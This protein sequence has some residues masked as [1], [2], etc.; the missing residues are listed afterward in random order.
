MFDWLYSVIDNLRPAS[1]RCS[2]PQTDGTVR[3]GEN[4]RR[5]ALCYTYALVMPIRGGRSGTRLRLQIVMVETFIE[6]LSTHDGLP[7]HSSDDLSKP[8]GLESYTLRLP[9]SHEI[10]P[11]PRTRRPVQSSPSAACWSLANRAVESIEALT[12]WTRRVAAV[13]ASL[14][15]TSSPSQHPPAPS[16]PA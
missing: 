9:T 1:L 13:A 10:I 3:R 2:R 4:P 12:N 15:L 14:G 11:R 16:D 6:L 8:S 7:V 5:P